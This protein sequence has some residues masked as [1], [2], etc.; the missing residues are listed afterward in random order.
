MGGVAVILAI[1]AMIFTAWQ[2]SDNPDGVYASVCRLSITVA[3]CIVKVVLLPFKWA[4]GRIP[5]LQ[6]IGSQYAGH[7][8]ISQAPD[9]REPY[10][11]RNGHVE[12]S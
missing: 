5:F 6:G 12:L 4:F 8:P 9:Y 2:I 10:R 3:G 1:A 7:H 11:G